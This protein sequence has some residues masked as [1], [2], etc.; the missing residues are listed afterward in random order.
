M[1]TGGGVD[2]D[3]SRV[4]GETIDEDLFESVLTA[5]GGDDND[6]DDD[7]E[8]DD[9]YVI[10]LMVAGMD[11]ESTVFETAADAGTTTTAELQAVLKVEPTAAWNEEPVE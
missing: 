10:D 3:E 2:D 6:D 4:V 7:D 8:N 1:R 11:N 9:E 5:D